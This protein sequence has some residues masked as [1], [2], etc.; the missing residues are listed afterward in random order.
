MSRAK[1]KHVQHCFQSVTTPAGRDASATA[2]MPLTS[3][4]HSDICNLVIAAA[5]CTEHHDA[6]LLFDGPQSRSMIRMECRW[7]L[8]GRNCSR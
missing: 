2:T 6:I 8:R 5:L 1:L 3:D 4:A 7:K